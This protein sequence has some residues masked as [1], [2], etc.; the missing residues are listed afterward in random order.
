MNYDPKIHHRRSIR[1]EGYDYTQPGYYFVTICCQD[2]EC[3]FGD[4]IDGQLMLNIAGEMIKN[5]WVETMAGL[6]NT[7]LQNHVIMPNHFHGIIE[8]VGVES[9]S[10]QSFRAIKFDY[11]NHGV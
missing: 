6:S 5:L 9:I 8:I 7:R 11:F 4:I 3:L 2:K 1:L 10:T